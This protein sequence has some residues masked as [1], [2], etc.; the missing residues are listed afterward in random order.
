MLKIDYV[1]FVQRNDR[2]LFRYPVLESPRTSAEEIRDQ[3]EG[4]EKNRKAIEIYPSIDFDDVSFGNDQ[5]ILVFL[6]NWL[7]V[8]KIFNRRR[9]FEPGPSGTRFDLEVRFEVDR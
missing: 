8:S 1:C 3:V 9:W 2:K 4:E 7:S 5:A 6:P